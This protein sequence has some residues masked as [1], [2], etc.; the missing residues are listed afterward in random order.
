MSELRL[1]ISYNVYI[2]DK[3]INSCFIMCCEWY[4]RNFVYKFMIETWKKLMGNHLHFQRSVL[5]WCFRYKTH[6]YFTTKIIKTFFWLQ[7]L[8]LVFVYENI[9]VIFTQTHTH[10]IVLLYHLNHTL[11]YLHSSLS[12]YTNTLLLVTTH[13]F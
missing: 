11:E 9:V 5:R 13:N 10:T 3:L 6:I 2:Q 12:Y 4:V 7:V 8:K 1:R